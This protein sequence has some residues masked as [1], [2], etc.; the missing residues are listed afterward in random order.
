M[1]FSSVKTTIDIRLYVRLGLLSFFLLDAMLVLL[2]SILDTSMLAIEML[3]LLQ[4]MRTGHGS[5]AVATF[6]LLPQFRK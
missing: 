4:A 1:F 2:R 3:L 5:L 6:V